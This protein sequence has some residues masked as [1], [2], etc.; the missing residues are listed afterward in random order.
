MNPITVARLLTLGLVSLLAYPAAAQDGLSNAELRSALSEAQQTVDR[1]EREVALLRTQNAELRAELADM[2]Q[3][4]SEMADQAGAAVERVQP[5]RPA[6]A[7]R[8][9]LPADPLGAPSAMYA[10]LAAAYR[11]A[12][13]PGEGQ[14]PIT[15][16]ERLD[17][18]E[19]FVKRPPVTRLRGRTTWF[20]RIDTS[21]DDAE[22]RDT[23][24]GLTVLA[25]DSLYPID[26][27]LRVT[28]PRRF[29]GLVERS[30]SGQIFELV[31]DIAATPAFNEDRA[32]PGPFN[33]PVLIGPY[34]E[35]GFDLSWR[36]L[37]P[38]TEQEIRDMFTEPPS[39]STPESSGDSSSSPERDQ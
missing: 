34:V 27:G 26:Q 14:P 13:A 33:Y 8:G 21:R 19:V 15:T 25:P 24:V 31:A 17:R 35:F 28:L 20:V 7:Q 32:E 6:P 23:E 2:N 18:A 4:L 36:R 10:A 1:L 38:R 16:E 9:A 11:T 29:E 12:M 5:P 30:T 22:T 39:E 3:R 37:I